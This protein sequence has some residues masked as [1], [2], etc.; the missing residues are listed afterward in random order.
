MHTRVVIKHREH[1]VS[2]G[3]QVISEIFINTLM[4]GQCSSVGF[5]LDKAC[6]IRDSGLNLV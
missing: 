6:F 4:V 5:Y 1:S 3:S 2:K